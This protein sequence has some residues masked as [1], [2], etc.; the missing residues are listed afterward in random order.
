M[1][2]ISLDSAIRFY[3]PP[4]QARK[5]G[6]VASKI[7]PATSVAA[8]TATVAASADGQGAESAESRQRDESVP[9]IDVDMG[10]TQTEMNAHPSDGPTACVRA[11]ERAQSG[12]GINGTVPALWPILRDLIAAG[13]WFHINDIISPSD[14]DNN[15]GDGFPTVEELL[16]SNGN[17]TALAPGSRGAIFRITVLV[18]KLT[19]PFLRQADRDRWCGRSRSRVCRTGRGR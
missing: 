6:P 18:R 7:S 8:A 11:L 16:F 3:V 15:D 19:S 12:D 10:L 13:S 5:P 1:A 4:Q 17:G 14:S 9:T 2:P